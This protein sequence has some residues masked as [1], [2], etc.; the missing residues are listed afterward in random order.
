M[1]LIPGVLG[2]I[3]CCLFDVNKI[4]W[5]SKKLNLLFP[6]GIALLICSTLLCILQTDFSLITEHFGIRHAAFLI[7]LILSGIALIYTLFFALPFENTYMESDELPVVNRGV[8]GL[9]RH[10]GFW[11]LALCYLFLWLFFSNK[12]LLAGFLLYTVCNF[13]YIYIQD[14]YIFPRY[15][16]GYDEYKKTVP[17]LIPNRNSIRNAFRRQHT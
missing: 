3:A 4:K 8:Y 14:R 7:C 17:F 16:R 12:Q 10:P 1:Y 13:I 6:I 9:C 2:F 11:M 15:I 5:Q